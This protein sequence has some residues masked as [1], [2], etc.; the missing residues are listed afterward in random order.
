MNK[1]THLNHQKRVTKVLLLTFWPILILGFLGSLLLEGSLTPMSSIT[2]TI[3]TIAL[4]V[5]TIFYLKKKLY[6]FSG[7]FLCFVVNSNIHTYIF[8]TEEASVLILALI[9]SMLLI[10]AM[11]LYL[12]KKIFIIY[13]AWFNVTTIGIALV[14]GKLAIDLSQFIII[15]V[16]MDFCAIILYVLTKWGF[17]MIQEAVVNEEKTTGLLKDMQNLMIVVQENTSL[18]NKDINNCNKDLMSTKEGSSNIVSVV[19]QIAIGASEQAKSISVVS[20][21]ISDADTMVSDTAAISKELSDLS[22]ES[23]I[24]VDDNA[25]QINEMK[26]QM[27]TIRNFVEDFSLTAKNLHASMDEINKLLGNITYIAKQTNLL[28]LNASIEA[29][30]AGEHGKGFAVVADE[31]GKLA[32]QSTNTVNLINAVVNDIRDNNEALQ[33]KIMIGTNATQVGVEIVEKVGQSFE[34]IQEFFERMDYDIDRELIAVDNTLQSFNKIREETS[35]MA[36]ISEEHSASSEEILSTIIEQDNRIEKMI[37]LLGHIK[38][39]SDRLADLV[40]QNQEDI[41]S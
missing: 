40:N 24:M 22:N 14:M 26:T 3:F 16:I 15:I 5:S 29:N 11:A 39:F 31:V 9:S 4:I 35:S 8:S 18:L 12:N 10:C 17:E 25:N 37:E 7:L 36:G 33:Q 1:T 23:R 21:M 28:S 34:K 27:D 19:E 13:S 38:I 6:L 41:R 32:T 30:R 2:F 20:E